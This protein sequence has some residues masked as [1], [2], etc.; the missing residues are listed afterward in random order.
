MGCSSDL[1]REKTSTTKISADFLVIGEDL[2][3][4]FQY[5]H[6]SE[7]DSGT[8]FNLTDELG[9]P[10]NYLT[11]VQQ[12]EVLSFY[13]FAQGS[14]TLAIKNTSTG[15][16]KIFENF[17]TNTPERSITWGINNEA[18]VF[19]GYFGALGGGNFALHDLQ[20]EGTD[21]EDV[22]VDFN[23]GATFRPLLYKEKVY[24]AFRDNQGNYKL[25][26]YDPMTMSTGRILNFGTVPI[27]FFST[28]SGNIAVVK[29][30]LNGDMEIYNPEDLSFKES[31]EM[32][33]SLGFAPG[34][35]D[36]AVLV[37]NEL[38]FNIIYPQPSR[39][40]KGPAI[41]NLATRETTVLNLPD[42]VGQ[43]ETEIGKAINFTVQ[44]YDPSHDVFLM[45][46]G[47]FGDDAEGG[48]V[49]TSVDGEL[50]QQTS[51]PFFPT[52]FLKN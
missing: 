16:T 48:V 1:E 33:I 30:E 20:L 51:L 43:V 40:V 42:L 6:D 41:Y 3:S 14:F 45:G 38:Y 44:V 50:L 32:D 37:G 17:Y 10:P 21:R 7:S 9:V 25:T 39:F 26:F 34:M 24:I 27:S 46:Y 52:Y 13:S 31:Y 19:F 49:A 28:E 22:T 35:I 47:T 11:L 18:N 23:V 12:N 2:T 29:N 36:D 4:V 5:S 15:E 8:T